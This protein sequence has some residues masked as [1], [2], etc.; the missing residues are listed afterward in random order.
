VSIRTSD[1]APSPA[2][3]KTASYTLTVADEE[4]YFDTSGGACTATLPASPREGQTHGIKK[5]GGSANELII[6][7]NGNRIQGSLTYTPRTGATVDGVYIRLR[8]STSTASL[9]WWEI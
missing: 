6:S 2:T 8:Y 7:G 9:G 5:I 4:L 1:P 3:T